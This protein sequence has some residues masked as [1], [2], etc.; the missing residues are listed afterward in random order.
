MLRSLKSTRL[1]RRR[2]DGHPAARWLIYLILVLG[3]VTMLAPLWWAFVTSLSDPLHYF[4]W[5]PRLWPKPVALENYT[6]GW[7]Y[8][9]FTRWLLNTVFL[10]VLGAAGN[11]LGNSMVGYAFAY[12]R[13]PGRDT[14]FFCMLAT[15]LI[16]AQI[17]MVP[18]YV[19]WSKL[20]M[21]NTWAPLLIPAFFAQP[22]NVFIYRQYLLSQTT[23]MLDA[24]EIDGAGPVQIYTKLVM[25]ICA[26]INLIIALWAVQWRWTD[27]FNPF[28]YLN[29]WM[30]KGTVALGLQVLRNA[31]WGG[32]P[33]WG[34]VLAV[35]LILSLVPLVIYTVVQR[36]F[37]EGFVF[38]GQK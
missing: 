25:P 6:L 26:P 32:I 27:W 4:S 16:P 29:D 19:L 36:R 10:A 15:M 33:Q 31:N 11:V 17:A 14:L 21:I 22:F 12:F 5:P 34:P 2:R 28:L 8:Y 23:E 24:A 38:T 37:V 3:A 18:T 30:K 7:T 9:P 1:F 20:H 13:F 35:S